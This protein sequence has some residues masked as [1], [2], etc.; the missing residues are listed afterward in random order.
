MT[1]KQQV[2]GKWKAIAGSVKQKYGQLTD[3]DLKRAEGDLDKLAGIIQQKTGQ[4]R[5]RIEAFFEECCD[6]AKSAP[7]TN[8]MAGQ[9][10]EIASGVG[11]SIRDGYDQATNQVRG[12][13]ITS[14]RT[15][16][17]HPL[18]SVGVA[19]GVG[20]VIGMLVGIPIGASQE[21]ALTWRE[22]WRR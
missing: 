18:A 13:Y 4:T 11:E 7:E 8:S 12:G 5:D 19:L 1:T 14:V 2:S 16:S 20:V 9:I 6:T 15:L 10:T 22:R 3:N 17:H 21:R